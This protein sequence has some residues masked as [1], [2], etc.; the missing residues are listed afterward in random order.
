MK[1]WHAEGLFGETSGD[2][3]TKFKGNMINQLELENGA[4]WI[5]AGTITPDFIVFWAYFLI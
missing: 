5:T 1:K 2:A 4:R 3:L